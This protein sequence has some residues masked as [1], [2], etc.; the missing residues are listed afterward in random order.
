MQRQR[1]LVSS[2]LIAQ[3]FIANVGPTRSFFLGQAAR[4]AGMGLPS[5]PCLPAQMFACRQQPPRPMLHR[6]C[7]EK[8][9]GEK[10]QADASGKPTAGVE[11]AAT[12]EEESATTSTTG[13]Q[14]QAP[15][16]GRGKGDEQDVDMMTFIFG[17]PGEF[18]RD[19]KMMG[20]SR[21]RFIGLNLF[22]LFFAFFANFAGVTSWALGLMPGL[23]GLYLLPPELTL[24]YPVKGWKRYVGEGAY[25]FIYPQ[26]WLADQ[27]VTFAN[28]A[29]GQQD[30]TM[31]AMPK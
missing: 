10:D 22:A 27:A 11:A 3:I 9:G 12:K 17:K 4:V 1:Q 30:Q 13:E 26:K 29:K 21:R 16:K 19:L 20:T 5:N 15:A 6:M 18:E 31:M 8:G 28:A 23:D 24:F 14:G 25:E 2:L 7:A